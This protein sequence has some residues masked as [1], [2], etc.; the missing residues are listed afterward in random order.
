MDE[1]ALRKYQRRNPITL[2]YTFSIPFRGGPAETCMKM[3]DSIITNSLLNSLSNIHPDI[4]A[5]R[6]TNFN[7]PLKPYS[8]CPK[9]GKNVMQPLKSKP[10][11]IQCPTCK[12]TVEW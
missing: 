10:P 9:C 3:I 6:F 1:E 12:Y 7:E 8:D 4:S 5:Q 11:K 2:T